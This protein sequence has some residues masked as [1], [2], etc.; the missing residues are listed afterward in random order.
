MVRYRVDEGAEDI[1]YPVWPDGNCF[2]GYG[3][4]CQFDLFH[5]LQFFKGVCAPRTIG[6]KICFFM[7]L[8]KKI[9]YLKIN[10]QLPEYLPDVQVR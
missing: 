5:H 3:Y 4:K 1:E 8:S 7:I 2:Q 9:L 6:T 10:V